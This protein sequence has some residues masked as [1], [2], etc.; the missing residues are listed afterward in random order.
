M[1]PSLR[2]QLKQWK[3]KN[4]VNTHSKKRHRQKPK[5]RRSEHLSESD[6]KSLM[7]MDMPTY[8]RH[9]GALRQR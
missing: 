5:K 2:D 3:R 6:I 7:G 4:K 1:H 9:K 8:R